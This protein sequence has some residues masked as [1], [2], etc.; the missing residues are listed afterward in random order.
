[1]KDSD[2]IIKGQGVVNLHKLPTEAIHRG[3][4]VNVKEMVKDCLRRGSFTYHH[5]WRD[6]KWSVKRDLTV[7]I[8]PPEDKNEG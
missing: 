8:Y 4:E 7:H 1:M 5:P 3:I 2:V 6:L